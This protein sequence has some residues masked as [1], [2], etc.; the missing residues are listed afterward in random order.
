[1][2]INKQNSLGLYKDI[3]IYLQHTKKRI[4][5]DIPIGS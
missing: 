2:G 1:M 5:E 4:F 3:Q